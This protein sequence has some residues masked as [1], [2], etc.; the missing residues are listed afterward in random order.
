MPSN[1]FNIS[2]IKMEFLSEVTNTELRDTSDN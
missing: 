2:G 1:N